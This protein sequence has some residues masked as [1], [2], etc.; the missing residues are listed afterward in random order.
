ML[1][2]VQHKIPLVTWWKNYNLGGSNGIT[3][4]VG[5]N[6]IQIATDGTVVTETSTDTLTNKTISGSSNTLSNIG[7]SSLS[8]SSI[9]LGDDYN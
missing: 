8:N 6:E 7:N 9:T 2:I 3:T 5:A 1:M 4:S